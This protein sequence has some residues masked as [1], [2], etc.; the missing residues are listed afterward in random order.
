PLAAAWTGGNELAIGRMSRPRG[1]DTSAL[2]L[3]AVGFAIFV[4]L[5]AAEGMARSRAGLALTILALA[6]AFAVARWSSLKLARVTPVGLLVG[7]VALASV[8]ILQFA[9]YRILERFDTSLLAD[10][11]SVIARTTIEAAEA[12]MPFGAGLGTFVPVYAMFERPQ[13]LMMG[14][15]VNHA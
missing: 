10:A 3:R 4:V 9:L 11:R 5:I 2:A 1:F 12:V 8:L 7:A 14:I 15:Y 13:D 6:G